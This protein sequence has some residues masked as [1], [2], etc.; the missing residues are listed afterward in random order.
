MLALIA[1]RGGLPKLLLQRLAQR[2]LVC[3]LEGYALDLSGV[4]TFRIE[5][6][7]SF[8]AMLKE[9][10]VTQVCFAGQVQRPALDPS[11]IDPA[12]MPLVPRMM[13]ALQQGDDAALRL[14]LTFFEEAGI[15]I[16]AAHDLVPELLP[17]EGVLTA[18]HPSDT[19]KQDAD[20]GLALLSQLSPAD[21][22]QSC[23]IARSQALAVEAQPGTD[24]ML[25]SLAA[26]ERPR[27]GVFV[28]AP[29]DGQD[30]RVD[31]PTIGPD[32]IR[33]VAEA[34]LNGLVIAAGGVQML[35]PQLC[36][37]SANDAGLFIWVRP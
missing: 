16:V 11:L 2:P 21:I 36:I 27:G 18:V 8:I 19:D 14:V 1:G 37:A 13:A 23:V 35:E 33:H 31:L 30:R 12:T 20:R 17:T 28:K 24:F 15:T 7:G 3:A 32:T 25:A 4:E 10:G 22:G 34:G 5:T 6:L 29:K 9:R 26:L